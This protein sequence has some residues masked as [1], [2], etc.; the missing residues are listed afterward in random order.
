MYLKMENLKYF[1]YKF[2]KLL[3]QWEQHN[4]CGENKERERER[5]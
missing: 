5:S 3:S 1:W 2:E 4:K